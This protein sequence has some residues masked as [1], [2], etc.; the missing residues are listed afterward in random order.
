MFV[1]FWGQSLGSLGK[2]GGRAVWT[3]DLWSLEPLRHGIPSLSGAWHTV[4]GG[5]TDLRSGGGIWTK[6]L[7]ILTEN[8]ASGALG[9]LQKNKKEI[10]PNA[11]PL[12]L[13]EAP[14]LRWAQP[15]LRDTPNF[16]LVCGSSIFK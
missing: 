5:H 3:A 12:Q 11:L 9:S 10:I 13:R 15:G 6:T 4:G 14:L 1:S 8:N 7:P 16:L 2:A